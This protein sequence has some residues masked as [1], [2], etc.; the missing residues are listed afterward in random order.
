[1]AL[2][3]ETTA[4]NTTTGQTILA[5]LSAVTP[6]A[7]HGPMLSWLRSPLG[8]AADQV[9]AAEFRARTKGLSS[10]EQVVETQSLEPPPGWKELRREIAEGGKVNEEVAKLARETGARL[11]ANDESLPPDP[12]TIVEMQIAAAIASAA[13]ELTGDP[14]SASTESPISAQPSRPMR[15]RSGQSPR[16][17]RCASPAPTALRAKRFLHLFM[18]SQ[19]EGGIRDLDRS[20]P[21]LSK[22][23]RDSLAMSTRRDPEVQE[24]YL[25]YS[26]LTVPIEGLWISCQTSD[27]A[28][29]AEQPSPLVA[30]VEELFATREDGTPEIRRGGRAGNDIVFSTGESPSLVEAARSIAASGVEP[31]I[32]FGEGEQ[33]ALVEASLARA[34]GESG[35][36]ALADIGLKSIL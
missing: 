10:A 4:R 30:S 14:D 28:G 8:P 19:Q 20:G 35:T 16:P 21:F 24:R 3:A 9:D 29:K 34:R 36:R 13:E 22:S 25:F 1:M 2:E 6:G 17:A 11:L 32:V 23:D 12:M 26:C 31:R 33:S 15:S 5:M 18:A 27:E 7:G